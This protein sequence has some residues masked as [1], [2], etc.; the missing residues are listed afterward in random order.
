MELECGGEKGWMRIASVDAETGNCPSVEWSRLGAAYRS[1][2]I[3]MECYSAFFNTHHVPNKE[4]VGLQK[5]KYLW[6]D[7]LN[8]KETKCHCLSLLHY[9]VVIHCCCQSGATRHS[10]F[11]TSN[12]L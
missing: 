1:L 10:V 11:F 3:K 4:V 7:G 8:S 2:V 12:A 5:G 6:V 9:T